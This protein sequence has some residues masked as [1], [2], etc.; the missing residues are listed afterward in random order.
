VAFLEPDSSRLLPT[1]PPPPRSPPSQRESPPYIFFF[2]SSRSPTQPGFIQKSL[3]L[4][5]PKRSSNKLL[6]YLSPSASPSQFPTLCLFCR[7]VFHLDPRKWVVLLFP[8]RHTF[9]RALSLQLE[10]LPPSF[11]PMRLIAGSPS[12]VSPYCASEFLQYDGIPSIP[13]ATV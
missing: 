5:P 11:P 7:F 10:V 9:Y 13:L 3:P 12:P 4:P 2:R 6:D 8:Q 1:I